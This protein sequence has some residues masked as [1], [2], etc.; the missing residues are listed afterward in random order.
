MGPESPVVAQDKAGGNDDESDVSRKMPDHKHV[1]KSHKTRS[2]M[3]QYAA[4]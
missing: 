1:S 3:N 2:I 4:A